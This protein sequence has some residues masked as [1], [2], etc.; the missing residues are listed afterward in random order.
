MNEQHVTINT[1]TIKLDSFLK[2]AG[3][4]STGGQAK[5]LISEKKVLVNGQ[6]EDKRTRK[7]VPGDIVSIKGIGD[8][9]LDHE[10]S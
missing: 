4:V 1:S 2:W 7:L 8:F 6:L 9:K 10:S 3:L 5:W